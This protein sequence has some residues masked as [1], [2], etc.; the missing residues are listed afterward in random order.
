V[1]RVVACN[2]QSVMDIGYEMVAA[3]WRMK[4]NP[5]FRSHRFIKLI[6][7]IPSHNN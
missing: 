2:F 3:I 4:M 6:K 1:V 7:D 5:L